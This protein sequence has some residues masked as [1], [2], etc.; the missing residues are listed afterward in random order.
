MEQKNQEKDLVVSV[1]CNVSSYWRNSSHVVRYANTPRI[2]SGLDSGS[3]KSTSMN[4]MRIVILDSWATPPHP[5][6]RNKF[7][8]AEYNTYQ[9]DYLRTVP[10]HP[11]GG[12]VASMVLQQLER[13]VEIHFVRIFGE[14]GEFA[15][16]DWEWVTDTIG[17][18]APN[19]IVCSWGVPDNDSQ[20][21]EFW[22]LALF[23]GDW[24]QRW[25]TATSLATTFWAS[26]NSDKNDFDDDVDAP[27]KFLFHKDTTGQYVIGSNNLNG[28]PSKFSGD[29]VD[30]RVMYPGENVYSVD[31]TDGSWLMWSGTSAAAPAACGDCASKLLVDRQVEE[32]FEREASRA[33]AYQYMADRHKKAGWGS[34]NHQ[35]EA[36][37]FRTGRWPN[38]L[39]RIGL[40]ILPAKK[41]W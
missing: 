34:M 27:Q 35:F 15:V 16:Q 12:W 19:Y 10:Q 38:L 40:S 6:Y 31:P 39:T 3:R 22:Q 8:N 13:P 2:R 32:Y 23:D 11:H 26:G 36:N 41:S 5:L 18:I 9:P 24:I 25:L 17:T 7:P 1:P 33:R 29:G 37:I 20:L 14:R 4:A 28:I 30:V 21:G